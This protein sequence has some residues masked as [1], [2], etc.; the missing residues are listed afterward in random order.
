MNSFE[1]FFLIIKKNT[2][3]IFFISFFCKGLV[4]FSPFYF[5]DV[6]DVKNFVFSIIIILFFTLL[7]FG[8]SKILSIFLKKIE[9]LILAKF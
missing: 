6:L 2:K 8:F 4:L 5:K 7:L 3:N 1:N 9:N